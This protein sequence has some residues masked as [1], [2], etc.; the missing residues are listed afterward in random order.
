MIEPCD[1]DLCHLGRSQPAACDRDA[2]GPSWEIF[3]RHDFLRTLEEFATDDPP[4]S[5]TSR[6]TS[7][8]WVLDLAPPSAKPNARLDFRDIDENLAGEL[9]V[10]MLVAVMHP[11]SRRLSIKTMVN[12]GMVLTMLGRW[13]THA[14]LTTV[15]DLGAGFGH[16]FM[17][18]LA[19]FV[20]E[21][22]GGTLDPDGGDWDPRARNGKGTRSMLLGAGGRITVEGANI[23][24]VS[25]IYI[26]EAAALMM[27]YCGAAVRGAPFETDVAAEVAATFHESVDRTTRRIPDAVLSRLLPAARAMLG[28]PAEDVRRLLVDYVALC[29]SGLTPSQAAGRLVGFEF[30]EVSK[31]AG[32]WC[33]GV[34]GRAAHPA[35]AIR[36]LLR[37]VLSAAL[38]L[39]LLGTGM[40]PGEVLGLMGG[41]RPRGDGNDW[42]PRC[43]TESSSKSGFSVAMLLHG[44]LFKHRRRPLPVSW[45][46]ALRQ[47]DEADPWVLTALRTIETLSDVLRPLAPEGARDMLL[48]DFAGRDFSRLVVDRVHA[49]KLAMMIRSSI[50]RFVDLSSIDP[51][52]EE[53]GR[54]LRPYVDSNGGCIAIYQCRKTYAQTLYAISP[55]LLIP[56]SRQY[57]HTSPDGTFTAYVTNDAVFARELET[58]RSRRTARLLHEALE[59]VVSDGPTMAPV[60]NRMLGAAAASPPDE[61][62]EAFLTR[63]RDVSGGL[64]RPG[65]LRPEAGTANLI[66]PA[67]AKTVGTGPMQMGLAAG[68][69][70]AGDRAAELG[71]VGPSVLRTWMAARRDV[72]AAIAACAPDGARPARDFAVEAARRLST[73]GYHLSGDP[74]ATDGGE[75]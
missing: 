62:R 13:M 65:R 53:A 32:A 69:T 70:M 34:G 43:V 16:L 8:E 56:I 12:V 15:S 55:N 36:S 40:R 49:A 20:T 6:F 3:K 41:R 18:A 25:L 1:A 44:H 26:H 61:V 75:A 22:H 14:R 68:P 23:V 33:E 58:Y 64:F 66:G 10:A 47:A 5:L 57:H 67:G 42:L 30:G 60:L 59:G 71:R 11:E 72:D 74:R 9:K 39:V 17:E 51:N 29:G 52:A 50:P 28:V 2:I 46:L 31:G 35:M 48:L 27:R 63:S 21:L 4:V 19:E 73:L 45:L 38:L 7:S 24:A 54:A 37:Q